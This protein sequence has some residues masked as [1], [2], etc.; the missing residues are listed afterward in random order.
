MFDVLPQLNWLAISLA[1]LAYF[2]LGA[3][4]FTPLFGAAYDTALGA[5]RGKGQK[6]P[7]IYYIGPFLSAFVTTVAMAVLAQALNVANIADALWLGIIVGAG[8]ALSVS[9]NNAIN[10]VTPRPLLYGAVTGGYHVVGISV[11]AVLLAAF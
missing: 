5:K 11:V 1:T 6:W 2:M 3:L 7:A 9:C 10:P 8:V 4:W